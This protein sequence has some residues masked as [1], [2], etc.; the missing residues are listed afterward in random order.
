MK[1]QSLLV[2]MFA[3]CAVSLQASGHRDPKNGSPA[4]KGGPQ[5][6]A[7][8]NMDMWDCQDATKFVIAS[9]PK[10]QATSFYVAYLGGYFGPS[11]TV[12]AQDGVYS[13]AAP[14]TTNT[15]QEYVFASLSWSNGVEVALTH[16]TGTGYALRAYYSYLTNGNNNTKP[17]SNASTYSNASSTLAIAGDSTGRAGRVTAA[18]GNYNLRGKNYGILECQHSIHHADGVKVFGSLGG[19]VGYL[20]HESTYNLTQYTNATISKNYQ[21]EQTIFGGPTASIYLSKVVGKGFGFYADARLTVNAAGVKHLA[22]EQNYT[23]TVSN[24]FDVNTQSTVNK[25]YNEEE[26]QLGLFWSHE[27]ENGG[28][29]ALIT[30]WR[31]GF[32]GNSNMLFSSTSGT[33]SLR[34]Q[35]LIYGLLSAGF[36]LTY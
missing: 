10:E 24:G 27:M 18:N 15:T 33:Q 22:Q 11:N 9:D 35:G 32:N 34:D 29:F 23:G 14:A 8:Q 2:G 31:A 19:A 13:T 12:I 1:K 36:Y 21:L 6:N 7:Q 30:D 16:N 26:L 28:M 25:L 20:S 17:F 5:K 4:P 3:L